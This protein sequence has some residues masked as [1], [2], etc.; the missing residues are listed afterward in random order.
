LLN[1][2]SIGAMQ[3]SRA[4]NNRRRLSMFGN[5]RRFLRPDVT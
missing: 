1:R 2:L 5:E 4:A 3:I